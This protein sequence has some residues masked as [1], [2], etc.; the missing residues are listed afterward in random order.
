MGLLNS[1]RKYCIMKKV[2]DRADDS[3]KKKAEQEE[4]REESHQMDLKEN[5][6]QD[7]K[8]DESKD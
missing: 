8:F 1:L 5:Y 3:E 2:R 6:E 7:E 4:M